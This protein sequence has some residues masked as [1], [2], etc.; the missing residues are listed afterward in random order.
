MAVPGHRGPDGE[1]LREKTHPPTQACRATGRVF[2]MLL[3]AA[4]A[5]SVASEGSE[6]Q[7]EGRADT[8]METEVVLSAEELVEAIQANAFEFTD[9]RWSVSADAGTHGGAN[10]LSMAGLEAKSTSAATIQVEDIAFLSF[11]A[12]A[13]VSTADEGDDAEGDGHSDS[14]VL[15]LA[16]LQ[17]G[18]LIEEQ[19]LGEGW[20]LFT[21]KIAPGKH[22]LSWRLT[23]VAVSVEVTADAKV[24]ILGAVNRFVPE[25]SGLPVR[26]VF[27]CELPQIVM[28]VLH[29]ADLDL[30]GAVVTVDG[31]IAGPLRVQSQAAVG[32][33]TLTRVSFELPAPA[34]AKG[35]VSVSA[36]IP[37]VTGLVGEIVDELI[38][39][40]TIEPS[41]RIYNRLYHDHRD[42]YLYHPWP[43]IEADLYACPSVRMKSAHFIVD[44]QRRSAPL[45]EGTFVHAGASIGNPATFVVAW[46]KVYHIEYTYDEELPY[47]SDHAVSAHYSARDGRS[48]RFD[49]TFREGLDKD[50][51]LLEP[52]ASTVALPRLELHGAAAGTWSTDAAYAAQ[53]VLDSKVKVPYATPLGA[54][55]SS[56]PALD[57]VVPA[58]DTWV[59][60]DAYYAPHKLVRAASLGPV[61]EDGELWL[62]TMDSRYAARY[63]LGALLVIRTY[64]DEGMQDLIGRKSVPYAGQIVEAAWRSAGIGA[65]DPPDLEGAQAE[66]VAQAST[67]LSGAPV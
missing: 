27:G 41:G 30:S 56:A 22:A 28:D 43:T 37:D 67:V 47:N 14:G 18:V 46:M 66:V 63:Q 40:A 60:L 42:G 55:S 12:A 6:E 54:G 13:A 50:T 9:D 17:D 19:A 11:Y 34:S 64:A 39:F 1:S 52:S 65:P 33:K 35:S 36:Q 62:P 26:V 5:G 2:V 23:L 8:S 3:L 7:A 4:P 59:A 24:E 61:I 44:G 21:Y 31:Q 51:I 49:M 16:F 48:W 15:K 53:V 25:L 20:E 10:V 38:D 57:E 45:G 58:G 29:L 32:L